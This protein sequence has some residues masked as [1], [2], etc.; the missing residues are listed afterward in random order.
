MLVIKLP[1]ESCYLSFFANT[2]LFLECFFV[3]L[4]NVADRNELTS[5]VI[6][7]NHVML[8]VACSCIETHYLVSLNYP[9]LRINLEAA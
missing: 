8:L 9:M 6:M 4:L 5:T 1:R 3:P 7:E 2:E